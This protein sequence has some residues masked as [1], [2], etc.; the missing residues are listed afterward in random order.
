VKH[1]SQLTS[2]TLNNLM[3]KLHKQTAHNEIMKNVFD[4]NPITALLSTLTEK[5]KIHF[6]NKPQVI[7]ASPTVLKKPTVIASLSKPERN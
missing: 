2:I 4:T 7:P 1:V 5:K 3:N 6:N